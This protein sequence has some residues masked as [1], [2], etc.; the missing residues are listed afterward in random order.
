MREKHVLNSCIQDRRAFLT[1]ADHVERDDLSEQGWII[2]QGICEYYDTDAG[3]NDIDAE[4]L[5]ANIARGV[6]AEKHKQMFTSLVASIAGFD[7]SVANV[8]ADLLATKREVKGN[9]LAAAI[10]AREDTAELLAEYDRLLGAQTLQEEEDEDARIGYSV[11]DLVAT[12]FNSANLIHISPTSLNDR[13]DGGVKPGH[14]IVLFARPEI[15]KTMMV[16][17]MMAG[18]ARQG[19]RTLYIGNEDPLDDINMR[20]VNRLSGMPKSE[21]IKKPADPTPAH[22]VDM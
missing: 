3:A 2:W 20:V 15:G 17:E 19:L 21:V 7:A 13:L 1:V 12:G 11:E 6:A 22:V 5:A 8:V 16:I 10:L 14:H 9:Q 4:I 18:F